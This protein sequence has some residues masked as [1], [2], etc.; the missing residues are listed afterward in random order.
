M[1]I[2]L[3]LNILFYAAAAMATKQ[4]KSTGGAGTLHVQNHSI[5]MLKRS[6]QQ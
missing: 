6:H 4:L 3:L 1:P 2:S 5:M